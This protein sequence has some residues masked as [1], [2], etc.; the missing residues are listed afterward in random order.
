[1]AI[2]STNSP[3]NT[4]KDLDPSTDYAYS[5]IAHYMTQESPEIINIVSYVAA[6]TA[7]DATNVDKSGSYTANWTPVAKATS[8]IINNYGVSKVEADGEVTLLEED[9]AKIDA[10]V[11]D[12][13]NML[14]GAVLGNTSL[15][16][17][18]VLTT[19]PGWTGTNN[20]VVQSGLGTTTGF[21]ATPPM[22]L[23][24]AEQYKLY[25]RIYG[26]Y[27]DQLY[28]ETP[29][30]TYA[31]DFSQD[32]SDATG[33]LGVVE[34]LATMTESGENYSLKFYSYYGP[35]GYPITI[36]YIKVSQDMKAGDE[37]YSFISQAEIPAGQ[38]SVNVSVSDYDYATYAYS[39]QALYNDGA[40]TVASPLSNKIL[41]NLDGS[42]PHGTTGISNAENVMTVS[43]VYSANGNKLQKFQKGVN[44][45]KMNDGSV[46]KV[47]IK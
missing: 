9:F 11:T 36:D 27:G 45:V 3:A 15:T 2:F 41:L 19:S 14:Q 38:T 30:E 39:V 43:D 37:V 17:F 40:T 31:F 44:I 4:I 28:M 13:T 22:Y 7:T 18:D 6:P 16:S 21:V 42:D 46:R 10:S 23:A 32:A 1:M 29:Y 12:A 25:I 20:V 33:T 24:N 26:Y 47:M 34:G 35:Y 8:Y 5:I